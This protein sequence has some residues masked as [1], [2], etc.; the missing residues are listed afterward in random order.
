[1]SYI[2]GDFWRSLGDY[3][4]QKNLVTLM[5]ALSTFQDLSLKLEAASHFFP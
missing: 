5:L 2:L 4:P 3:F 1:M